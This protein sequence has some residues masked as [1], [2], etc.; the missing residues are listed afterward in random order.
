MI[1]DSRVATYPVA[2]GIVQEEAPSAINIT[3]ADGKICVTGTYDHLSIYT[4]AGQAVDP[5]LPLTRGNYI[6]KVT[7]G[8]HVTTRKINVK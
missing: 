5:S 1:F 6:V 4:A 3:V 8:K 7:N 2:S